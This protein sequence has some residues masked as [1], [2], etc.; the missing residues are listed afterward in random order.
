MTRSSGLSTSHTSFTPSA[1]TCGFEPRPKRAMA[2]AGEVTLRALGEDG[3]PR[4]GCRCPARSSAAP[5]RCG[6][7]PWSPV[8][9][10]TT[11]PPLTS[12]LR[13]A[14]SGTIVDA[15]LLRALGEPARRSRRPTRR[16]SRGSTSAAASG[17]AAPASR[18]EVEASCST[19]GETACRPR[20]CPGKSWRNARGLTT[21][22]ERRCAPGR[23]AL[24]DDRDRHVA[25]A[26]PRAPAAPAG[27]AR[28]GWRRRARRGPR[29]RRGSRRRSARPSGSVGSAMNSSGS[30]GGGKSAGL[31]REA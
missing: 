21:A 8:R 1:Y 11:R 15:E 13:A 16:S 27:A 31:T 24:L 3:H 23:L 10:P 22:P 26:A 25:R 4:A 30:N 2:T 5:R 9:T 12:S 7:R 18:Q 14:V 6:P 20:A 19:R 17:S 28:R 29:R